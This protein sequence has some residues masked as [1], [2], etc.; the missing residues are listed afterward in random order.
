MPAQRGAV[1]L[2]LI[3]GIVVALVYAGTM[4]FS[5]PASNSAPQAS[6]PASSDWDRYKESTIDQIILEEN[7][8]A[9]I[10]KGKKDSV[11]QYN[12]RGIHNPY[13]VR[14][15]YKNEYRKITSQKMEFLKNWGKSLSIE[16]QM[17]LF[18]NETLLA[19]GDKEY[20]MP[21]QNQLISALKEEAAVNGFVDL[22]IM[23]VGTYL[24]SGTYNWVFII[25]E[26]EAQ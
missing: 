6:P 18:E 12:A 24:E 21:I 9:I 2:L 11:Y 25:N 15:R 1:P 14:S 4:I 16:D 26:F 13:K 3:V 7:E 8:F 17:E 5:N 20:W 22:F 10:P 19:D 23:F